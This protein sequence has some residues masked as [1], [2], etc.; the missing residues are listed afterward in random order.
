[1]INDESIASSSEEKHAV[2]GRN[3]SSPS[4]RVLVSCVL[5]TLCVCHLREL[6]SFERCLRELGNDCD[7]HCAQK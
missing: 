3:V 6:G 1:M 7:V 5:C 2:R 4:A